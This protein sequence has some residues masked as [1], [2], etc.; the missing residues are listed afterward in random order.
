MR[1]LKTQRASVTCPRSH[2]FLVKGKLI[3][4][5]NSPCGKEPMALTIMYFSNNT[6]QYFRGLSWK[7]KWRE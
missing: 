4:R 1:K 3:F 5:T 6:K 7:E 2:V